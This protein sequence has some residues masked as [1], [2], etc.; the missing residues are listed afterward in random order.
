MNGA[1]IVATTLLIIFWIFILLLCI[2]PWIGIGVL[3]YIVLFVFLGAAVILLIVYAYNVDAF[4]NVGWETLVI[5]LLLLAAVFVG[6]FVAWYFVRKYLK[7]YAHAVVNQP[8]V[9]YDEC[10]NVI[11]YQ[12]SKWL[13]LD[14]EYHHD[15]HHDHKGHRDPYTNI[16]LTP[17]AYHREQMHKHEHHHTPA[18]NRFENH[19]EKLESEVCEIGIPVQIIEKP[20]TVWSHTLLE[21]GSCST[22]D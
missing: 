12:N 22:C 19:N 2:T 9:L 13:E 3:P 6:I 15:K 21:G 11:E 20:Q 4:D 16:R 7:K 18:G 1:F 8:P 14:K 10:G 17:E 5:I